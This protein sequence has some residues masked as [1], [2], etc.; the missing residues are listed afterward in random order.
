VWISLGLLYAIG[1]LWRM[2]EVIVNTVELSSNA[3]MVRKLMVLLDYIYGL[4]QLSFCISDCK[5][6]ERSD[7]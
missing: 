2:Q 1:Q 5:T 4:V 7:P 3:I 6:K